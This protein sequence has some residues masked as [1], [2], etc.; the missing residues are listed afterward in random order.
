MLARILF[1]FCLIGTALVQATV[2]PAWWPLE[3][4]P[5]FVL[6]L[7]IVW[8]VLRG[9]SEGI[10]WA[11]IV[12]ILLDVLA[13][14]PLGTNGLALLSAVLIAGLARQ[15]IFRSNLVLP[16][17]LTIVAAIVQPFVL[18]LLGSW[19]GRG[20]LPIS[21]VLRAVAPQALLCALFLPPIYA[22]FGW[23]IQRSPEVQR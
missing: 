11:A 1:G 7:I 5:N 19:A 8:T 12:G 16:F 18:A 14:D 6:I 20:D 9:I 21:A 23:F 4:R 17:I 13:L 2:L 10:L 3:I 15:R 22:I